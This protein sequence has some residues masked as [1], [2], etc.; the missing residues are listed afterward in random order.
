MGTVLRLRRRRRCM[1]RA[2]REITRRNVNIATP[3]PTPAFAPVVKSGD[4][5][6]AVSPGSVGEVAGVAGGV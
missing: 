1:A 6:P 3:T 2:M 5:D 4:G